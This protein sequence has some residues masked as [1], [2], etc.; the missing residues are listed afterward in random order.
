MKTK[1]KDKKPAPV[2]K[3][4]AKPISDKFVSQGNTFVF[5]PKKD[6]K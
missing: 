3:P 2:P 6:K 4:Q 5:L 1:E